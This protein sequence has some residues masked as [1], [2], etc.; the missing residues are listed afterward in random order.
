MR[1]LYEVLYADETMLIINKSAGLLAIPDRYDSSKMNLRAL[2]QKKYGEIFT[3]HRLDKDTSGVICFARNVDAQRSLTNQFE[4]RSVEK[5]Y[6][7]IVDGIPPHGQQTI[8]LP[9][10]QH[11][12]KPGYMVVHQQGKPAKTTYEVKDTFQR[13]AVVEIAIQSGRQH[14]IRVHFQAIG[15]PLVVDEKYGNRSHFMLSEIK[16]RR[17]KLGKDQTEKPLLKRL[18]LHAR[19][20]VVNHPVTNATITQEAVLPKDLMAIQKQMGKWMQENDR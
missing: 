10:A 13:F 19:R 6:W 2:L 20:I 9:L 16:G 14:Q 5:N 17:Y 1:A 4:V 18:S 11:A 12:F 8:E 15:H 7:A 3:V